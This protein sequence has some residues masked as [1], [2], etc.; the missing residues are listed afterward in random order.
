MLIADLEHDGI[1]LTSIP[2]YYQGDELMDECRPNIN[3]ISGQNGSGKSAV[4]QAIQQASRLSILSLLQ[5]TE[6]L[7]LTSAVKQAHQHISLIN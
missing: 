7:D 3:F 1:S 4:L 6:P 5:H 2:S